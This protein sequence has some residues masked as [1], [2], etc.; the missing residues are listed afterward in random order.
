MNRDP[1][2]D[3]DLL[4]ENFGE[5]RAF[6]GEETAGAGV[7]RP[8]LH[9]REVRMA[10]SK[11][12]Q[13]LFDLLRARGLRKSV[14]RKVSSAASSTS[15]KVPKQVR[16]VLGDLRGLAGEVEDRV[17]GK[18]GKRKAAA[19]KAARTRKRN[20]AKRSASAKKAAKTRAKAAS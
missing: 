20:A 15:G 8:E 6:A 19:E 7:R 18:A 17:T 9:R 2:S 11:R 10:R 1:K 3:R 13:E 12:E 4:P 16:D 14:A 5:E